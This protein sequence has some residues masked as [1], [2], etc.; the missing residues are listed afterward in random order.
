MD[1]ISGEVRASSAISH[2]GRLGDLAIDT[3]YPIANFVLNVLQGT[4]SGQA[5]LFIYPIEGTYPTARVNFTLYHDGHIG[6]VWA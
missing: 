2:L 4:A 6:G 1:S 5:R 3:G